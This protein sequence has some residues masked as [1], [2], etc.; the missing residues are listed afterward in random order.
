MDDVG[1]FHGHIVPVTMVDGFKTEDEAW[2]FLERCEAAGNPVVT[3]DDDEIEAT[4]FGHTLEPKCL[5]HPELKDGLAPY[6][7]HHLPN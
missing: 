6:F 2:R 1:E 4:Y 7:L 5:C 3:N